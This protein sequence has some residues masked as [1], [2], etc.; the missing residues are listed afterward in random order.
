MGES[1]TIETRKDRPYAAIPVSVRMEELGSVV[2]PLTGQVFDWLGAQGVAPA[3]PPFW[4]YLVVDMES[5]SSKPGFRS[6]AWSRVMG[7][8]ALAYCLPAGT[9]RLCTRVIQTLS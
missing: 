1:P 7:K 8:F 2:P 9:P 3:G 5:W 4:R 6:R